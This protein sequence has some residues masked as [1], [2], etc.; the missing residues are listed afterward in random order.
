MVAESKGFL[1]SI[2]FLAV[3]ALSIVGCGGGGGGGGGTASA[4][5]TTISGKVALSS[6]VG[7]STAL[8]AKPLGA[9]APMMA[10]AKGR[11]YGKAM[12]GSPSS[13]GN[14]LG[15][16]AQRAASRAASWIS[17]ATVSLYDADHPE[18]LYPVAT[19]DTDS[20]GSFTLSALKNAAKNSNAYT[21]GGAIPSGNYTLIAIGYDYS[22]SAVTTTTYPYYDT[23]E[24]KAYRLIVG[25]QG[26]VSKF[27]GDVTGNDL[28]VQSS[29]ASPKVVSLMGRKASDISTNS[30]GE[31]DLGSIASNSAIQVIFDMAMH[32]ANTPSAIKL[33]DSSGNV[34]SGTWKMSP[35]LTVATF[36][37]SSTLTE[38]ANYKVTISSTA[39]ANYYGKGIKSDITVVYK[40]SAPD[41]IA[42]NAILTSPETQTGVDVTTAIKFAVNEAIDTNACAV[43]ST[44]SI[45]AKPAINT[46]GYK[47]VAGQYDYS[48]Q[49]VPGDALQLN[50]TYSITLSGCT[51][52]SGQAMSSVTF[53]FQTASTSSGVTGSG[54][55]ADAQTDIKATV[56][57]WVDAMNSSDITLFSS[58][59]SGDF[60]MSYEKKDKGTR[61]DPGMDCSYD[62]NKDG[63]LSYDEFV[64]F[65]EAWFNRNEKNANWTGDTSG[66]HLVGEVVEVDRNGDGDTTDADDGIKV[67]T[68]TGTAAFA[69]RMTYK[70]AAGNIAT[71]DN[72]DSVIEI[73]V[74]VRN[75][76]GSWYL[77]SISGT[78]NTGAV[79]SSVGSITTGNPTGEQATGTKTVTFNWNTTS[80]VSSYAVVLLDN[81]D[82]TGSTG[83]VGIVNASNFSGSSATFDYS[84]VADI[85]PSSDGKVIF[86]G[87]S[88][89]GPFAKELKLQDG[90]SYT[91]MVA[92]FKTLTASSFT[93]MMEKEPDSDIIAMSSGTSFSI[94]GT[95]TAGLTVT[96]QDSTGANLSFSDSLYAWNAGSAS[97]ATLSISTTSGSTEGKVYMYGNY[98]AEK[99]ITFT[100]GTAK[101]TIDLFEGYTWIDVTDGVNWWYAST[102]Q[103]KTNYASNYI[104]T[105]GGVSYSQL[106][107]DSVT[108]GTSAL[109]MD[110][111]GYYNIPLTTTA[112]KVTI[113]GKASAGTVYLYNSTSTTYDTSSAVVSSGAYTAEVPIYSGYN[114]ISVYDGYGNWAYVNI[115]NAGSGATY[116]SPISD[117]KVNSAGPAGGTGTNYTVNTTSD[118]TISGSLKNSGNGYW[119]AYNYTN[120]KY[121]SGTL[122]NNSNS[123]SFPLTVYGGDTYVD[124]YDANWNWYGITINNTSTAI[125][126]QPNTITYIDG[127]AQ[128]PTQYNYYYFD[129]ST[130]GSNNCSVTIDGKAPSSGNKSIYVYL[131]NYNTSTYQS[132]Y[133]YQTITADS[134]G[135][136]QFTM[137]VGAGTNYIDVY[138]N[139]WNWQGVQVTGGSSCTGGIITLSSD[140][141]VGTTKLG[142]TSGW[143]Y[144]A[145]SASTVTVTGTAKAGKTVSVY[146]YAYPGSMYVSNTYTTTAYTDLSGNQI[147]SID[148]PIYNGYNYFTINDGSN[149]L[150]PTVYTTGGATYTPPINTVKVD[151]TAASSGG[152]TSDTWG[153]WSTDAGS[154]TITGNGTVNGAG[155]YYLSSSYTYT[156]GSLS[157]SNGS[158]SLPLSLDYG[159]NYISL[160]DANWNYYS[161]TIYTT[162]GNNA[163]KKYVAITSPAHNTT[164]SGNITVTGTVDTSTGFTPAYVYGYVYDYNSYSYKYYYWDGVT[165]A[166]TI[167]SWGYLP[168][169]YSAGAFSFDASVTSGSSPTFI[170]VYAYDANWYS[171]GHEIYVNNTWGYSEYFWKP[172]KKASQKDDIA[173]AHKTEFLKKMMKDKAKKKARR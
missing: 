78:D 117:V 129:D 160:Y 52:L 154:V 29:D 106:T 16:V 112:T 79:G 1:W 132:I 111:Y 141:Y 21:D 108:S 74:I 68:T 151:G 94:A 165:D 71:M 85:D 28:T 168:I 86:I 142:L 110:A 45:G 64:K 66:I 81:A 56:G 13:P 26:V 61:C 31:Y 89:N 83:W 134:S 8:K 137:N 95:K 92:G 34:I 51:D 116:Q 99:P 130:S 119:Y 46:L 12:K 147:Y 35:D 37:P 63:Q 143:Y 93:S 166:T 50:T 135:N 131:Y 72:G 70:D 115:Y 58:M 173:K 103:T 102:N 23:T 60:S 39:T 36:Y 69:F 15:K 163:P 114:W 139:N 49:I 27:E 125:S 122:F 20:N 145:S 43:T 24:G 167:A 100:N 53:D 91:W 10:N 2:V 5:T 148:V 14:R 126:G 128:T 59:L 113:K 32:R 153:S 82:P 73:Y 172:G 161:V 84:S 164:Q 107:V 155:Y 120:S 87:G 162:G 136:Y 150:Y 90:G 105:T 146:L 97:S 121:Y 48:Y 25:V 18:W 152:G 96:P 140:I 38:N 171:H 88:V 67:D 98:Y 62:L 144:D 6:T 41:G 109:S 80:G 11:P 17:G 30:A 159:W 149:W 77:S 40:A 158:F 101:V 75:V 33:K 3:A 170:E 44:P 156:S 54:T 127:A 124:L 133:D 22:T 42:P 7:G 76:N 57:K 138:D 169:T 47:N 65:I 19:A 104:Y 55:V 123:F 157:I 9:S 4:S 118:V